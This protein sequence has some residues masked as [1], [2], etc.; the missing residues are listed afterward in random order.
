MGLGRSILAVVLA[1]L[2]ALAPFL[3]PARDAQAHAP[4]LCRAGEDPA[5]E[6]PKAPPPHPFACGACC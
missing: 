3:A 2:L 1:W 4:A 5:R 6:D